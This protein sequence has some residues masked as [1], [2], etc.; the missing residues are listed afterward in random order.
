MNWRNII[1][2]LVMLGCLIW[3]VT[4]AI[5]LFKA[6]P[7]VFPWGELAD[8]SRKKQALLIKIE[9]E[10]KSLADPGPEPSQ[11]WHPLDHYL[12]QKDADA[13]KAALDHIDNYQR[14]LA[15]IQQQIDSK[16]RSF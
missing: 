9:I 8:L 2:V 14:D 11:F 3:A 1:V 10:K 16:T 7:V 4:L 5:G 15:G 12:W 13:R 6:Q